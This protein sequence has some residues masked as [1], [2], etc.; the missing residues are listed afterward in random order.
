MGVQEQGVVSR[1]EIEEGRPKE[2]EDLAEVKMLGPSDRK[3]NVNFK[4]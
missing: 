1:S 4:E 2:I 3:L